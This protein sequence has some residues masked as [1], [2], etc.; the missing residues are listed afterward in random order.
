MLVTSDTEFYSHIKRYQR[1][2]NTCCLGLLLLPSEEVKQID[3]LQRLRSGK[4]KLTHPL[5][6]MFHFEEA[7]HENLFI[8]LR[9]N[10][11]EV[12]ELCDCEWDVDV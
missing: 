5:A 11:P 7:R 8:N 6:D 3:L 4:L 1:E 12:K 10:P 9:A 2:R